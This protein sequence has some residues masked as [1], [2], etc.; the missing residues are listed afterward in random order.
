MNNS[1]FKVK[2]GTVITTTGDNPCLKHSDQA[3]VNQAFY[4]K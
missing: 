1:G 2:T 3:I 4:L